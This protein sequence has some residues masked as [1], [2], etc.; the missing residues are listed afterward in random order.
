MTC[1]TNAIN[2]TATGAGSYSWDNG[3][4]NVAA[5][6]ITSA[7]LYTVTVTGTNGCSSTASITVTANTT[8]PTAGITNNTGSTQLTCTRTSIS[9]TATGAGSYSWDNN[10]GSN[11]TVSIVDP[12]LYTVTVTGTN[13]CSSTASI[14]ITQGAGVPTVGYTASATTVCA[15]TAVTLSGTGADTYTWTG[16]ITNGVS[17]IPTATA[18]YT[19]TGTVTVGGCSNAETVTITVVPRPTG[20]ISGAASIC[21][22]ASTNLSIAVTGNG[23]WNG[24]L[25][26]GTIF[27]GSS[28]PITVTVSPLTNTVYTIS[29]LSASSCPAQLSDLTGSA[30]I[31]LN[32]FA[33]PDTIVGSR[34]ACL[35]SATSTLNATYSI[36]A[37]NASAYAWTLP[38]G[39]TLISGAGTNT[40][41]VHYAST[42]TTGT[43]SVQVSSNCGSPITKTTSITK[44][45]SAAPA[46]ISGPTSVCAYIGTSTQATYTSA[47]VAGAIKYSWTLPSTVTIVSATSDSSIINVTFGV[48]YVT[49]TFSVKAVVGCGTTTAKTLS[50]TGTTTA[51]V[52]GTAN[53]RCGAGLISFS[54]TPGAGETIDWYSAATAG[55]LLRSAS[56]TFDSTFTTTGTKT[57]YAAARNSANGCLSA[58]RTAVT[59]IINVL[60]TAVTVSVSAASCGTSSVTLSATV[61]ASTTLSWFADSSTIGTVLGTGA[62]FTTP[63]ISATTKYF[64]ASQST[65]NSCFSTSLKSAI[66]TINTVPDLTTVNTTQS[67]CG[68]GSIILTATA[69]TG[70]AVWFHNAVGG[71]ALTTAT[72]ATVTYTTPV[73]S[74]SDSTYYVATKSTSGCFSARTAVLAQILSGANAPTAVNNSRCGAGN[75]SVGAT[76]GAGETIDWYS[77]ATAGTLLRSGSLTLDTSVT[78]ASKTFYAAAR[79]LSAGCVSTIRTAVVATYNALPTAVTVSVS[80]AGCGSSSVTLSATVPA[81]TTLSWFADS[82]TIGTVLGTGAT[83]TT[84]VISA[85]TKYFV[86]SQ[87]TTNSCFSTSLKSAI[88]TINTVPDLTTVNT[89]QSRCGTG[90]I[91]LTA[92]APTGSAVWFHNAVGG[93]ALTTATT[94]TVTYT[95]PVTSASDST[96]YVATKS[97]SGCFSARTAVLAKVLTLPVTPVTSG[98]SRCGA[99]TV[100][101][102]AIP[103]AG[104]TINWY[105]AAT[106]GTLLATSSNTYSPVSISAT[107][108]YYAEATNGTC[109]SVRSAAVATVNALPAVSVGVPT[110][111]CGAGA[112]TVSATPL[113]GMTIDWYSASTAGTLLLSGSNSYTTTITATTSFY[114]A[115]RNLT[116][117]CVSAT[118]TAVAATLNALPATVATVTAAS[119]C[120]T[121]T[122]TLKATAAASTTIDWYADTLRTSLIQ[123]GT[124]TGVNSYLT[125]VTS[126]TTT[127]WVVGRNLTT[128]CVSAASKPVALTINAVPGLPT[129]NT[130]QSRCGTGSI[131]LTATAPTGSAVWF[132]D[133]TISTA[134]TT[135][136]TATVTYTTPVTSANDS[137]YYVSTK[138]TA[139]CFSARTAVLAKINAVPAAP[140]TSG[141]SVCGISRATVSAST[142]VTDG[143]I[144]WYS[145]TTA[146]TLLRSNSLTFDS[147]ISATKTFYA[148]TR[149]TT[150]GC[151]S[152]TRTAAV[153]TYIALLA[154]PTTLT[155]TTSICP[156]VGTTTGATYT[157]TA[158]TGAVS[159]QWTIPAGAVLDSG[160]NGLK[161][162]IHFVTA[163]PVDSIYVQAVATTGCSG[164]KKVLKLVT[165]SCV[166]LA[167]KPTI[168]AAELMSVNVFPNPTT[169][170]F[171]VRVV[172]AGKE[173]I[174]ARIYDVQG[175]FIKSVI[176][177]PYETINIGSELKAGTYMVEVRQGKNLKTTRVLKF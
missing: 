172:T 21:S 29:T 70:S 119:R 74:A 128:G 169:S 173:V 83:F 109:N 49:S 136:T 134:L 151:L 100:T 147:L 168:S 56:I 89:T 7:G 41:T 146:G 132:R 164:T 124:V 154:A 16:G 81:S 54:A 12:G 175:R 88:A 63:V 76:P 95:T 91:I 158:V 149:V 143:T 43:I 13:G 6:S 75:I 59:A 118:R 10:L 57:L 58:T 131:I 162:K 78:T 68:T 141:T 171:N 3:L 163:G 139:G 32:S 50:V 27:S 130:T 103:G 39:A 17:F 71:T 152:A 125:P 114:A 111:R 177:N 110:S 14:T 166:T 20:N 176:I 61:P 25:S 44:T 122:A 107:T 23:P 37:T 156:I 52:A 77:A 45:L 38:A 90:S 4:G 135:A 35:Y 82:S 113:T 22:G 127:Y 121:D 98:T 34:N 117:G 106:A 108:T 93:T 174:T 96:Y 79:N 153:A 19:V 8:A 123:S 157:A 2:V 138:S 126:S 160:S 144:D 92:T 80:A 142:T 51:P 18:S 167:V 24:T 40:I 161:I 133:A 115:T 9:V 65:T 137:T 105:S 11:A 155:G 69:P 26:D 42:F 165:T 64:V 55:I 66:A 33:V 150:T 85:T 67:R 101:V 62:T 99:G 30:S 159:Y 36:A 15:G 120:G 60:P 53:T 87:S 116:T 170:S 46:S 28:T 1:N 94:A 47:V 48:S 102:S 73:T 140:T 5:A 148:L 129:V 145:A 112:V 97:T 72:T 31:T 86:A 104:E 84:P